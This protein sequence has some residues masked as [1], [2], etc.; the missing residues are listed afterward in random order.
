MAEKTM[1]EILQA[2]SPASAEAI[3]GFFAALMAGPAL[4][5]TTKELVYL[6]AAAA[7]GHVRGVPTHAARAKAAGA[8]R[9]QVLEALLLTVPAAGL[10]PISQCLPAAIA[11]FDG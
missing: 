5:A 3:R 9:Q 8:T 2:E 4:D 6:V 11:A 10:G 7:A 1:M